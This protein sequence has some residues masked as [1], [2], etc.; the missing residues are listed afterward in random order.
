MPSAERIERVYTAVCQALTRLL[1]S[2]TFEEW[3]K[4]QKLQDGDLIVFNNSFL[5][6]ENLTVTTK[7]KKYLCVTCGP[8]AEPAVLQV[9]VGRFNSPSNALRVSRSISRSTSTEG[10]NSALR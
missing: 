1:G 7:S 9:D 5:Y 10:T 2:H 8:D 3:R 4:G 6:R